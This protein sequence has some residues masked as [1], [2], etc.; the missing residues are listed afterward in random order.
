MSENSWKSPSTL[1]GIVGTIVAIGGLYLGYQQFIKPSDPTPIHNEK[2]DPVG[3][4][5][6]ARIKE[7]QDEIK[8]CNDNI[9]NYQQR[10]Q[11]IEVEN[12]D[13]YHVDENSLSTDELR[14]NLAKRADVDRDLKELNDM[15]QENKDRRDQAQNKLDGMGH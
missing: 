7:L 13:L 9:A 15:I 4:K 14:D 10:K 3:E 11:Q 6:A 2:P 8:L 12:S 5:D 1:L